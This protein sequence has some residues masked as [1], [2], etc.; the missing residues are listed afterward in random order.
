MLILRLGN[1]YGLNIWDFKMPDGLTPHFIAKY[2]ALY[3]ILHKSHFNVYTLKLSINFV[4]HLT[5]HVSKFKF[6]I[7]DQTGNKRC[8]RKWML[9]N[10]S[11]SL[12]SKAYSANT[13]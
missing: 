3:E 7:K 9:L 6:T 8:G 5:I 1:T 10:T 11:Q 4:A 2:V 12:K 13:P